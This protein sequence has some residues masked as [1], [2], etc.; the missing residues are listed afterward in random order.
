M[1][2]VRWDIRTEAL[3]QKSSEMR[4]EPFEPATALQH[5][6]P[7]ESEWRAEGTLGPPTWGGEMVGRQSDDPAK[8]CPRE[9]NLDAN[10]DCPSL[11]WRV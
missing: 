1:P 6:E 5:D 2:E 8:C 7:F 3:P 4:R 11:A 9:S 10:H